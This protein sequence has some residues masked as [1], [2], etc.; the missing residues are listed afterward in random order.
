MKSFNKNIISKSITYENKIS[1]DKWLKLQEIIRVSGVDI[2]IDRDNEMFLS[3]EGEERADIE[4]FPLKNQYNGE[5]VHVQLWYY[6]FFNERLNNKYL[7]TNHSF[8]GI[9]ATLEF[10]NSLYRDVKFDKKYKEL[11]I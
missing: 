3:I 10:I 9:P 1:K 11:N 8:S 4:L 7:E 5:F 6:T 2:K